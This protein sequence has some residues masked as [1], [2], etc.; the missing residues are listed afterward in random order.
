MHARSRHPFSYL[1]QLTPYIHPFTS[2]HHSKTKPQQALLLVI[3]ELFINQWT[4]STILSRI[5]KH[6]LYLPLSSPSKVNV[7]LYT[8]FF[9]QAITIQLTVLAPWAT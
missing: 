2:L 9:P 7:A 6:L 5:G 3:S 4:W 1:I 8:N